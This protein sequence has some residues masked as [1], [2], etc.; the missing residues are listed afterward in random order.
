MKRLLIVCLLVCCITAPAQDKNDGFYGDWKGELKVPNNS[1][2]FYMHVAKGDSGATA[3]IDIQ[4][5]TGIPLQDVTVDGDSMSCVLNSP[6]G[7]MTMTGTL[8]DG[9]VKVDGT[10][11]QNGQDFAFSMVPGA[12]EVVMAEVAI[13]KKQL[14][15]TIKGM[16]EYSIELAEL[17]PADKYD[18]KPIED[19]FSFEEQVLHV[20]NATN[21]FASVTFSE[22]PPAQIQVTGKEEAVAALKKT[23][24][25]LHKLLED[26]SD[27]ELREV[28]ASGK[29][30]MQSLL[31]ALNHL[32]HHRGMMIIYVRMQGITP[33]QYR[34]Y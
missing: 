34:A 14:L 1:I 9:G 32:T 23:G 8:I 6:Q 26:S 27:D 11:S 4:G 5:F 30:R 18:Y 20:A 7:P 13:S 24:M 21:Y 17:M 16:Y 15:E 12:F 29:T 28:L 3:T 10:A 22:S 2:P 19:V 25:Y 31:L 33:P